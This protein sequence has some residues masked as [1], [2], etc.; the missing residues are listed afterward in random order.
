MVDILFWSFFIWE[1]KILLRK[2]ENKDVIGYVNFSFYCYSFVLREQ[3]L[4]TKIEK[5][6]CIILYGC[7]V[8]FHVYLFHHGIISN[9]HGLCDVFRMI[10]SQSLCL[11]LKSYAY[12]HQKRKNTCG[13]QWNNYF[14]CM[15]AVSFTL[16]KVMA[17]N[18]LQWS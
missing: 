8:E 5:C 6:Q 7:H 12:D 3:G 18:V 14:P 2:P 9:F 16:I 17:F 15:L 1:W 10:L 11:S 13:L 4:E